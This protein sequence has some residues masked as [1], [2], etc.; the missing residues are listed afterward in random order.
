MPKDE[1]FFKFIKEWANKEWP[2]LHAKHHPI[3]EDAAVGWV[4]LSVFATEWTVIDIKPNAVSYRVQACGNL[5]DPSEKNR[6]SNEIWHEVNLHVGDPQYLEKLKPLVESS[7]AFTV[8][9]INNQGGRHDTVQA[10]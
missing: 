10:S 8:E 9:S 1:I 5:Y 2:G 7:L 6:L 3:W 4:Q